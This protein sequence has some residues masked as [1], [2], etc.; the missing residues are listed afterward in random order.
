MKFNKISCLSF[1]VGY[2]VIPFI[3]GVKDLINFF[4]TIDVG[5]FLAILWGFLVEWK[6]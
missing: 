3:F 6:F 4:I 1:F 5:L 2:C